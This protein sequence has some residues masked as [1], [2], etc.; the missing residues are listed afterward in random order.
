MEN[1]KSLFI[2]SSEK[3][4]ATL[5]SG[6]MQNFISTGAVANG[7]CVVSDK[8]VYFR[9]KCYY[10]SG[11]Y[12][13]Q[14]KEERT[15]DLKDITGTGFTS[16][17]NIL[18]LY[19]SIAC[20][21]FGVIML[22]L[23]IQSGNFDFGNCKMLFTSW[24]PTFGSVLAYIFYR[25]RLFEISYAGGKIAFKA[26]AYTEEEM[27]SFQKSLRMAKDNNIEQEA[28][29]KVVVE[30]SPNSSLADELKKYKDLLDTG[31]ISKEEYEELKR[32]SIN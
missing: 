28:F 23:F 8:R 19:V 25:M 12:Y 32:K 14:T 9:G 18:W 17:K 21:V 5:G 31:A 3:Q 11:T 7:F 20:A 13:R 4:I 1:L 30:T 10:K 15:V 22:S 6:Y 26:S 24:L 27:H 29:R 16:T 2:D